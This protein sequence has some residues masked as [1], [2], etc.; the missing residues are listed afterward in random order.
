MV[1]VTSTAQTTGGGLVRHI[2][3]ENIQ[4]VFPHCSIPM[5][6]ISENCGQEVEQLSSLDSET[7]LLSILY[8]RRY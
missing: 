6:R 2:T 4:I 3:Q 5:V 8:P 1:S 7:P